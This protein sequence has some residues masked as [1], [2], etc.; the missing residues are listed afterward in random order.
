[1][2][3]VRRPAIRTKHTS[4][5]ADLVKGAIAGAVATAVMGAVTTALYEREDRSARRREDQ[6]RGGKT[7]YGA[8]AE[9]GA[10]AA[11]TALTPAER[12]QAGKAI[13]WALGIGAGATYAVLRRRI[14]P[15]LGRGAGLA[16]GSGFWLF[17]D[18]IAVPALG[19]TPGPTAF[20]WQTHARGLA[21]HL[22]FGAVADATL[23]VLDRV[24]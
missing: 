4:V 8:A 10:A 24:M 2:R 3:R 12:E 16:F 9:K 14:T 15:V 22:S 23:N 1:M 21:G 5:G 13:H 18:E 6:A 19:L 7:A 11:G 20:P 17:L